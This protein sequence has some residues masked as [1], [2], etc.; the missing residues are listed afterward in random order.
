MRHQ[1]EEEGEERLVGREGLGELAV[2]DRVVRQHLQR[3]VDQR[4]EG[5]VRRAR[6]D[7]VQQLDE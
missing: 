6:R 2:A 4:V 7:G 3:L 5:R 1:A